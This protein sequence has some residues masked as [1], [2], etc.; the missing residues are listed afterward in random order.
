[1]IIL[2]AE[3]NSQNLFYRTPFG[4]QPCAEVVTLRLGLQ[5]ESWPDSVYLCYTTNKEPERRIGMHFHSTMLD[6]TYYEAKLMLPASPCLLFYTF[7][8]RANNTTYFYGNNTLRRGGIG[9]LTQETPLPYQITVYDPDYKTPDWFRGGVMYQ[10]F[11]DRFARGKDTN[12]LSVRTD[13]LP[14]TW[15]DTPYYK[16][17]QFGGAYLANDFFGGNLKGITEKLDYLSDLGVQ[18]LYL[19]PIFKA[20]SNHK[21]DTGDYE[22][23][24]PMF[25]TEDDFV[26]LCKSAEENGIRIVLDGVFN[27]TGSD[28]KYFNKNG[29]YPTVGA[30]Q[31]KASPY[32]DWY[33]FKTFPDQYTC[34]WGIKT[35]PHVNELSPSYVDY[36]LTG[37]DAII[38]KW[39]RLGASGWRL[40]VVDE[41]PGTFVKT[42][43][44]AVKSE[45]EDA[46]IIGEVWEDASNKISYGEQREYLNGHELDSA[47]NYPLRD[48]L[49]KFTLGHIGGAEFN[50]RI[51][52]LKENYPPQAFMAMMNFLSSH[53]TERILTVLSGADSHLSRDE[54]AEFMLY[55]EDLEKAKARLRLITA[56]QMTLPGTPCI[57]YGDETAMQGFGDPFCRRCFPWG[58]TDTELTDFFK[59]IIKTRTQNDALKSGQFET[60]YGEGPASAYLR[61]TEN[62]IML[63]ACNTETAHDWNM[64]LELGKYGAKQ[65]KCLHTAEAHHSENGRFN[66]NLPPC[67]YKIMEVEL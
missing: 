27:H 2:K 46:V 13:I 17:E 16:S 41:L 39:L 66:I 29:S 58:Q 61:Y 28:S 22:C 62:K 5:A 40:D 14:R 36:I 15:G 43:R 21:Y 20:Y 64:T 47:M 8:I 45:K 24:D 19:N 7:E 44:K 1:M 59:A 10:I 30:Y 32:A 60:V 49:I 53:D 4:A 50:A 55:G 65:L 34:W 57:Y 23:I 63:I 67:S 25:G 52:T 3:H 6:T 26:N 56:L 11:C 38:K 31:D 9:M 18:T 37:K 12:S 35:L 33:S 42:L 48:A 51:N 54:Q